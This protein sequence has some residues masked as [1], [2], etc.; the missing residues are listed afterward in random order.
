MLKLLLRDAPR[1]LIR[2]A[3]TAFV[4][5]LFIHSSLIP[6]AL[7]QTAPTATTPDP[8]A[9]ATTIN[10]QDSQTYVDQQ[11][12]NLQTAQSGG[13][14][15]GSI[16]NGGNRSIEDLRKDYKQECETDLKRAEAGQSSTANTTGELDSASLGQKILLCGLV[17]S[18]LQTAEVERVEEIT[19]IAVV[20]I[21]TLGCTLGK[22]PYGAALVAA[23][24]IGNV[25]ATVAT[26]LA[27]AVLQKNI[28][29]AIMNA[30]S[31]VQGA[32]KGI[33][34]N[35]KTAGKLFS[36]KGRSELK[37]NKAKTKSGGGEEEED[38]NDSCG[39]L[40]MALLEVAQHLMKKNSA[41]Q[42]AEDTLNGIHKLKSNA[43]GGPQALALSMANSDL[44]GNAALGNAKVNNTTGNAAG[45]GNGDTG[46]SGACGGGTGTSALTMSCARSMDGNIPKG[47][48]DK[49]LTD[50]MDKRG[51]PGFF[52][53]DPLTDANAAQAMQDMS[54]LPM[55][56]G[57]LLDMAKSAVMAGTGLGQNTAPSAPSGEV[58]YSQSTG[59]DRAPASEDKSL[60]DMMAAMMGGMDKDKGPETPGFDRDLEFRYSKDPKSLGDDPRVSIF[61]RVSFRY[62][63]VD[64]RTGFAAVVPAPPPGSGQ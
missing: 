50:V 12:T 14:G 4:V 9:P 29:G 57:P 7:A 2:S 49:T 33:G 1:V 39:T 54:G 32:S 64:K 60:E 30:V 40:V 28:N 34:G 43:G 5:L 27:D 19:W 46:L 52:D 8:N 21:C 25:A 17:K 56:F 42:V 16:V 44:N 48:G 41:K 55:D 37:A 36:S 20:A 18:A 63:T 11:Q 53:R 62:K 24:S 13:G 51:G 10:G 23:C 58:K 59:S 6:L 3:K 26:T 35:L 15:L 45:A 47:F 38:E 22:T 31:S 61:R